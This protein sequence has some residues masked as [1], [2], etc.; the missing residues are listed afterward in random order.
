MNYKRRST[1]F[2]IVELIIVIAIIGIL[3]ALTAIGVGSWRENVAKTEV[4]SDLDS[5]QAAMEDVRNRTNEYPTT[6]PAGTEFN[7]DSEYTK[8][9]F[10]ESEYVKATYVRGTASGYCIDIQS[11]VRPNVYRFL[12]VANGNGTAKTGTCD[13][14]EGATP[15][16]PNQTIFVFDT[17]APGCTGTVKLPVDQPTSGGTIRW[18]DGSTEPLSSSHQSH[19]YSSPGVYAVVYDGPL[20]SVTGIWADQ[21][22]RCLTKVTQWGNTATPTKVNFDY[23]NN[24]VSVAE[25]PH[26]VTDM[27]YMFRTGAGSSVFNQDISGWDV[28]NVKQMSYM[29][30]GTELFN[31]NISA[32]DTSSVTRMDG[33]FEGASSFNQPIGSWNTSKVTYMDAMFLNATNFNQAISGWN[34]SKVTSMKMMFN[35]ASSFNQNIGGWSVGAVTDWDNFRSYSGLSVA[36]T[37][38]K[39]L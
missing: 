19:T 20:N 2:T 36:N 22:M 9:I 25:P 21:S 10:I 11:K 14:G 15:P 8:A 31:R 5:L 34:T 33:M 1:A 12:E 26:T 13:G 32:W 23:A 29:F 27:T 24:L 4:K 16:S 39:F 38:P 3:A 6:I 30:S 28:S 35:G 18:G 17:T 7:G 37:P